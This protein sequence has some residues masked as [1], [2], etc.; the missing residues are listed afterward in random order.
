MRL[1]QDSTE[2]IYPFYQQNASKL[3]RPANDAIIIFDKGLAFKILRHNSN[4]RDTFDLTADRFRKIGMDS[5]IPN[6]KEYFYSMPGYNSPY[7]HIICLQIEDIQSDIHDPDEYNRMIHKVVGQAFIYACNDLH[8]RFISISFPFFERFRPYLGTT[9]D[10]LEEI[11]IFSMLIPQS[12]YINIINQPDYYAWVQRERGQQKELE[13]IKLYLAESSKNNNMSNTNDLD[14]YNK[15]A[16]KLQEKLRKMNT[17]KKS[18]QKKI[19]AEYMK[20]YNGRQ[21][22]LAEAIGCDKCEISRYASGKHVPRSKERMLAIA[23]FIG[24]H[25]EDMY[26]FMNGTG[27]EY[28]ID[29]RDNLIEK[30]HDNQIFDYKEITAILND[31]CFN[32]TPIAREELLV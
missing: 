8:A 16:S 12:G 28:P 7:R 22:E 21:A 10:V 23:L 3:L 6:E 18:A 32:K 11:E 9:P 25:H 30:A 2:D 4:C 31:V 19:M 26:I 1:S 14:R 13:N 20:K 29:L 17:N 24:L 15:Y 27:F 5:D